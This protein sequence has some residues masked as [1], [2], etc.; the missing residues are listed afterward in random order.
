MGTPLVHT[1]NHDRRSVL[2]V[3][4]SLSAAGNPVIRRLRAIIADIRS[5]H[6]ARVWMNRVRL[7]ILLVVSLT[8]KMNISLSSFAPGNL[9]IECFYDSSPPPQTIDCIKKKMKSIYRYRRSN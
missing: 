4:L 3:V 5:S 7:P 8:G 6:I 1:V 2:G 9:V